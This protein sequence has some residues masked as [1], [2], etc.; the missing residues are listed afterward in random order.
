MRKH[1]I[2]FVVSATGLFLFYGHAD[3][4]S[5]AS[6]GEQAFERNCALCHRDGGNLI[7]PAKTLHGKDL[8]ENGITKPADIVAKMR[9]PGPGMTTFDRKTIPDKEAKAIGD[10]VLK[11]FK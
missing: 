6:T 8:R 1:L 7:N 4:A 3:P 10:Y 5:K 2:L 9:N 11:A